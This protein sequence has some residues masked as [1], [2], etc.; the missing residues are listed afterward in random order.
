MAKRSH[1][2]SEVKVRRMLPKLDKEGRLMC[3]FCTPSHPLIAGKQTACG[4]EIEVYASQMIYR[5]K[6]AN[7]TCLKCG[8]GG[9]EMVRFQNGYVH[10]HDCV[11]GQVL[12]VE[13]PEYSDWAKFIYGWPEFLKRPL[14]KKLG[15]ARP[16]KEIDPN[17]KETGNI[18]GYFFWKGLNQ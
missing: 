8:Q 2:K 7:L 14:E 3:P 12:M 4:T 13:E 9:G 10:T 11:P 18:L 6:S 16:V 1:P 5:A 17:G 15:M